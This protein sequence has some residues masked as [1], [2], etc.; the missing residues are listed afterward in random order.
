MGTGVSAVGKRLSKSIGFS[1]D[2]FTAEVFCHGEFR[3]E[4][5]YS[6]NSNVE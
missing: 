4:K 1:S 3:T 5:M 2:A 6:L